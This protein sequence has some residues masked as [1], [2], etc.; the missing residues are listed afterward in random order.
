MNSY[1]I[2]TTLCASAIAMG[3]LIPAPAYAEDEASPAELGEVEL[4]TQVY[5]V[6]SLRL[7]PTDGVE[8]ISGD[9]VWDSFFISAERIE[10]E[11]GATLTFSS[12][13]IAQRGNLYIM[14]NEIVSLDQSD[15]GTITWAANPLAVPPDRGNAASAGGY[16]GDERLG[17]PGASGG[18]GNRGYSGTDGP[19]LTMVVGNP[20]S[21]IIVELAGQP[22]GQGGRGETGGRGGVGGNGRSASQS[23]VDCKRGA[24][25]G[26]RGGT[27]GN[28]GSGGTGGTGG[29]GGTF[30]LVTSED[31][32][33]LATTLLRV[34]LGQGVGGAGG[35][36]GNPG[37]GGDGGRGGAQ[38]LPYCRGN[39]ANGQPG[40]PGGA[41]GQ[42]A[43]GTAGQ[44]GDFII[45]GLSTDDLAQVLQDY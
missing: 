30:V 39:G 42:G 19:S 40:Q 23:A 1:K 10:F 24:G 9:R 25:D 44:P 35:V 26:A 4:N 41:G 38:Q 5:N 36:A 15:P 34:R 45:G 32:L 33:A 28:G 2:S 7:P 14:A 18:A 3:L 37:P 6:E 13:A 17:S 29:D 11:P 31:E 8:R 12:D 27:G 22:G 20:T 16:P 43:T 21:P